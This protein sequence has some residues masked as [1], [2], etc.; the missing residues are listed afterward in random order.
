MVVI[1]ALASFYVIIAPLS[2][3]GSSGVFITKPANTQEHLQ[4]FQT[5]VNSPAYKKGIKPTFK[6]NFRGRQDRKPYYSDSYERRRYHSNSHERTSNHN[7]TKSTNS[8]NH[9]TS[10]S[11]KPVLTSKGTSLQN[12]LKLVVNLKTVLK[13]IPIAALKRKTNC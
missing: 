3:E 9:S 4:A 13:K 1:D 8:D 11:D 5:F 6:K 12:V 2:M 7:Q 10:K